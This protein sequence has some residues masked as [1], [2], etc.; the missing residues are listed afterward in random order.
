MEI[1]SHH[2][3]QLLMM[4]HKEDVT[5]ST[6]CTRRFVVVIS[7]DLLRGNELISDR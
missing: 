4:M 2:G 5:E 1:A 3:S 6:P 7:Q